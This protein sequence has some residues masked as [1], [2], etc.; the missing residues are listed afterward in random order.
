[1]GLELKKGDQIIVAVDTSG[2][3]G[4]VD[5]ACNGV[6]KYEWMQETLMSYVKA[7][8]AFDPDG[9]SVH[10]FSDRVQAYQ[11]VSDVEKVRLLCRQHIVGGGTHTERVL[12]SAWDEHVAKKNLS[13]YLLVFTDG[14]ATDRPA[15]KQTIV[16]ITQ[17]VRNPEEFRIVFLPVGTPDSSLAAFLDELD[18]SLQGAKYDIVAIVD[19]AHAD[20][21]G[22]INDAIGGTTTAA[23]AGEGQTAGKKTQHI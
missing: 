17:K 3:M 7:A 4:E 2:S 21:E 6:R 22:A 12:L 15:V 23:D 16:G 13:T 8:A 10:F 20:F 5:P 19:P 11:D 18:E 1:M 14:D 9:I